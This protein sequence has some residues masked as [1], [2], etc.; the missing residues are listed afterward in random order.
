MILSTLA[1]EPLPWPSAEELRM[2]RSIASF[3]LLEATRHGEYRATFHG[4]RVHAR[5]QP[6]ALGDDARVDVILGVLS[7]NACG[8]VT[9]RATAGTEPSACVAVMAGEDVP[10]ERWPGGASRVVR[11]LCQP[12]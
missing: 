12:G 6:Q 7:P 1:G 3:A 4:F 9:V 5:R 11:W 2:L 10:L 8:W